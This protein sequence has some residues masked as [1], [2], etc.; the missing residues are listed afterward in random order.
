MLSRPAPHGTIAQE[1][2]TGIS[3]VVDS[4]YTDPVGQKVHLSSV[5]ITDNAGTSTYTPGTVTSGGGPQ[6]CATD[7]SAPAYVYLNEVSGAT[8][9]QVPDESLDS[10]Q[11]DTGGQFRQVDGMYIYNFPVANLPDKSATYQFGI[12]VGSSTAV[13]AGVTAF[14]VK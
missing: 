4:G 10:T 7:N 9:G 5:Q 14:G 13:P 11:G 1:P 6:T 8:P 2:V 3:L 12:E